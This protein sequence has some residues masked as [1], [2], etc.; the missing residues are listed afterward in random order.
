V[1]KNTTRALIQLSRAPRRLQDQF[2]HLIQT[3]LPLFKIRI[4]AIQFVGDDGVEVV[5]FRFLRLHLVR[6]GPVGSGYFQNG[7][8]L[9][10]PQF[11]PIQRCFSGAC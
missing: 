8:S 10:F 5:E 2:D 3:A 4:L 11:P 7:N 9:F 6:Y 1:S